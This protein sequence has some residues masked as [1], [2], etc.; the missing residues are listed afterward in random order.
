MN[1][2]VVPI[3]YIRAESKH[4][5]GCGF[6]SYCVHKFTVY[7]IFLILRRSRKKAGK[8]TSEKR[9]LK[10]L[11]IELLAECIQNLSEQTSGGH[12]NL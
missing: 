4:F 10:R 12:V 3:Y 11:K 8:V 2:I 1:M 6:E 9:S 7:Y 5:G